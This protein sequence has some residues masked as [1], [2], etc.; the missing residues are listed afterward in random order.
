MKYIIII[1]TVLLSILSV[2]IPSKYEFLSYF[3]S[4]NK[5]LRHKSKNITEQDIV[6]SIHERKLDAMAPSLMAITRHET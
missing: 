5:K 2:E 6:Q 1:K 4:A 3:L